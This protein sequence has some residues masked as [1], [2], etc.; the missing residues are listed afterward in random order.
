MVMADVYQA[1][2]TVG[3]RV[4][5]QPIVLKMDPRVK[6]TRADLQLQFKLSRSVEAAI[7][8]TAAARKDV[9]ARL[10]A[11]APGA[12]SLLQSVRDRLDA[13]AARLPDLFLTLQ[14]ADVR[15]TAATEA[16]V[17]DALQ[18]VATAIAAY[19]ALQ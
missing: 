14:A 13:A 10:A 12:A 9:R 5:R 3:P 2:L 19:R 1:R 16:A 7:R 6:T 18:R 17:N 8:D 4:Y 11:A 15:P